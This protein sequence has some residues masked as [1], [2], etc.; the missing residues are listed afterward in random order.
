MLLAGTVSRLPLTGAGIA[1]V[2]GVGSATG[3]YA[4]AGAASATYVVSAAV[5][6]P[7]LA[8][9]MDATGQ[10]RVLGL[11][12]LV[13]T[14]ALIGLA[15]AC[16]RIP[17]PAVLVVL[18]GAAGLVGIDIGSAVRTRWAAL[19]HR[20]E[21]RRVAFV[22]ESVVDETMFVITPLAVTS[23]ALLHPALGLLVV[24]LGPMLGWTALAL[25]TATAPRPQP[26][27]V[28]ARRGAP[29]ITRPPVRRL[30]ITFV[31]I[32][33]YLGSIE[34]LLVALADR[35]GRPAEAG[36][37]LACWAAGSAGAALLLGSRIG[38][39]PPVRVFVGGVAV[40]SGFGLLLPAGAGVVWLAGVCF[41]AGIGAAPAL[42]AG[43][44]MAGDAVGADRRTEAMT[45]MSTGLGAGT[46]AG[47]LAGGLVADRVADQDA[48][49]LCSAVG[50]CALAAVLWAA[51]SVPDNREAPPST[52]PSTDER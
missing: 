26:R 16:A 1:I 6:A 36:I 9:L 12:A 18:S 22:L 37:A 20:D 25:Q 38:R 42:G 52:E 5:C 8:R 29:V 4:I 10:R 40:M 50:L 3:S 15:A 35:A 13:Q 41:C 17:H 33:A 34:V 45:W 30:A 31:G 47:A 7:A 14:A 49:L 51:R 48:Y 2:L 27:S 44:G 43:F 11:A 21:A 32:G 28:H 23:A 19:L 39:V 24:A 46:T